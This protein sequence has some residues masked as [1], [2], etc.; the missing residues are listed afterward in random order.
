[1]GSHRNRGSGEDSGGGPSGALEATQAKPKSPQGHKNG[2]GGVLDGGWGPRGN[3][4]WS[5]KGVQDETS[6]GSRR[7]L[8]EGT[9]GRPGG[10]LE[11]SKEVG[12]S[13]KEGV[14]KWI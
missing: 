11:W 9:G 13:A 14:Q 10:V 2:P 3:P 8:G 4:F 6:M 5:Q 7:D 1:M 12:K